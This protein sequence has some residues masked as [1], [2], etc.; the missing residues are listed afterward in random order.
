MEE[1]VWAW[2]ARRLTEANSDLGTIP[3]DLSPI[4]V[5][6]SSFARLPILVDPQTRKL[7]WGLACAPAAV[8]GVE[9][10]GLVGG[11]SGCFSIASL[12]AWQDVNQIQMSLEATSDEF[13]SNCQLKSTFVF[14]KFYKKES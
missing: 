13:W 1:G 11:C 3:K 6:F 9:G 12:I 4:S 5:P 7:D 8:A 10:R 14:C 2:A